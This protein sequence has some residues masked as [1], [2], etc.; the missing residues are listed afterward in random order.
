[1]KVNQTNWKYGTCSCPFFI[2]NFMCK[3]H[4]A[5]RLDLQL[6]GCTLP[7]LAKQIPLGQKINRGAPNKAQKALIKQFF[8][9]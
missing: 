5:I 8:F 7:I 4:I 9:R 6:D 1:M 2:K 3:H